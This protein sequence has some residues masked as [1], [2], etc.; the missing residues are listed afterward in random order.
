MTSRSVVVKNGAGAQQ[1]T[2][3]APENHQVDVN[4]Q[5]SIGVSILAKPKGIRSQKLAPPSGWIWV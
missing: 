5:S 4:L 1:V 2:S 3:T